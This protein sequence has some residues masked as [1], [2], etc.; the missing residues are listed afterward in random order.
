MFDPQ[1]EKFKHFV[2]N[3]EDPNSLSD[4]VVQDII[5]DSKGNLWVCTNNG[6]NKFNY[7]SEDFTIYRQFTL[8]SRKLFAS[9]ITSIIQDNSGILWI[10]TLQ[11]LFKF[12]PNRKKF[13]LY[14]QDSSGE[15][16]FTNNYVA[17]LFR[18]NKDIILVGTWGTGLYVYNRSDGQVT[19]ISSSNSALKNDFIHVIYQ[20]SQD[21]IWLGTQNGIYHFN[22]STNAIKQVYNV[23]YSRI[24][25]NNRI[26]SIEE[27]NSGHCWIA[28]RYGLH[29]IYNDS[30]RSYYLDPRD[31]LSLSS[32]LVY[33]IEED[34]QGFIWIA[35]QNGLDRLDPVN[36]KMKHYKRSTADCRTCISNNEVLYIYESRLDSTLWFGTISGLNKYDRIN[37][38]FEVYTEKDG[39]TNNLIY[40]IEEDDKG[41]LWISTNRGLSRFKPVEEEFYNFSIT[42]GLQNYEFNIASSYRSNDGEIFFGGISG[43][44]SFYPDSIKINISPPKLEITLFEVVYKDERKVYNIKDR[45]YLKLAHKNTLI[46]IEFAALEYTDPGKNIYAYKLE[47]VENEWIDIGTRRYASFSNLPPGEYTFHVKG[48]NS[49]LVWNEEGLEIDILVKTPVWRTKSAIVIYVVV[50]ILMVYIL[51]QYRTRAL[52][53]SNQELKDKERIAKQVAKQKEELTIKNKNITDSIIYA[54]RIQEALLPSKNLISKI[55]YTSFILH[56]PK[57]IVS[58]DFYWVNEID[59]KIFIAVVD[60]TGHGVPGAFM[61]IIG[62]EL[63]RKITDEKRITEADKIL[64]ELNNGIATTFV[65]DDDRTVK[66]RDGMDLALCVIDKKERILEFA[67][68]FRP[69][70]FIRDNKIEE[71]RGDRFSVGLLDEQEDE[72]ITKTTINLLKDDIFYLFSDGYA[73]QFGGPEGKKYK[74]RRFRHLLLTIHKL[75]FEQQKLYLDKSIEDWKGTLEQVDD[76]LIMGIKPLGN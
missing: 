17:S 18:V 61:S 44:N 9:S 49:D 56:K 7:S 39:L 12:Q 34:Y 51:I 36:G 16:L 22:V 6:L 47:G 33:D 53:K 1:K 13:M 50:L 27:D 42:D 23:K 26:Y 75:P 48:A 28:T 73:D 69:L 38:Q 71:I 31:S 25:K 72:K 45:E 67:G 35:T 15:N 14:S 57:D 40:A 11:G 30:I 10:G 74:Y 3:P 41:N 46:N 55:I 58:G 60:C 2:A 63:L 32:N 4:N 29:N 5:D 24:F 76:I 62:F 64:Y 66:L 54:K 19:K 52:R 21:N 43:F 37:D 59:D 68:A 70:Y 20:D 8:D 65:K